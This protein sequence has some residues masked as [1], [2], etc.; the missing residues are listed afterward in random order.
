MAK[1]FGWNSA[2]RPI[3]T[4]AS[5]LLWDTTPRT[6][7]LADTILSATQSVD[8]TMETVDP[9]G[10]TITL[11]SLAYAKAKLFAT[12]EVTPNFGPCKLLIDFKILQSMM[13]AM[14]SKGFGPTIT[15]HAMQDNSSD[16]H[17]AKRN[18]KVGYPLIV[19]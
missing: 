15:K 1:I 18:F 13:N 19:D 10:F 2:K 5:G 11:Q 12:G 7:S 17:Q 9:M 8:F 4:V 16:T 6:L 3:F 14:V